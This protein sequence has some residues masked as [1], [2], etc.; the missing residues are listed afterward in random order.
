MSESI[1]KTGRVINAARGFFKVE[2]PDGVFDCVARGIFRLEKNAPVVGDVVTI[3]VQE[4]ADPLISS[5][6]KR[7]NHL[8]RPP[9]AN[10][11]LAILVVSTKEPVP[12]QFVL[13][14][15]ICILENKEIQ[16]LLVF[17]K[18]DLCRVDELAKMYRDIGYDVLFVNN[19][20][21]EGVKEVLDAIQG[22]NCVMLGNSG[23]GKT[24]LLNLLLPE[25]EAKTGEISKKLGRGR[26]TTRTVTQYTTSNGAKIMDTPGFS[27][28]EI[29]QYGVIDKKEIKYCFR[30]FRQYEDDCRFLDCLH[31]GEKHCGI[32]TALEQGLIAKERY[33]SYLRLFKE[34]EASQSW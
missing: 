30:E 16:P 22:K 7:K 21:G 20:T 27:T 32:K 28:V 5:I 9:V 34:T 3:H 19:I 15:L 17:T 23:V 29:K 18:K 4:K 6:H 26:H 31:I 2:T 25:I 8:V 1:Y 14:K 10:I 12:N 11:D 24:S 33:E 13:D